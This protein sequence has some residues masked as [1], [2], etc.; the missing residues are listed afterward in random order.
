MVMANAQRLICTR[1][2]VLLKIIWQSVKWALQDFNK[3]SKKHM[4]FYV[5]WWTHLFKNIK[6]TWYS[7]KV[8][9]RLQLQQCKLIDLTFV[10]KLCLCPR[11]DLRLASGFSLSLFF[12]IGLF[13][14]LRGVVSYYLYCLWCCEVYVKLIIT[15]R[16]K[17][18]D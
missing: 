9:A 6:H 7:G 5:N 4:D 17:R 8:G 16:Q 15:T 11:L 2:F 14:V 1:Q 13:S 10:S 18:N 3:T 12:K